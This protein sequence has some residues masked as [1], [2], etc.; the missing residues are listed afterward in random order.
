MTRLWGDVITA[1]VIMALSVYVIVQALDLPL[2]GGAM[3][4]FAAGF[5][6]VLAIAW[7]VRDV[8]GLNPGTGER[9][10]FDWSYDNLKPLV[11]VALT[12]AY[13][14]LMTVI[15]FFATTALFVVLGS[16]A[17][18]TRNLRLLTITTVA[19]VVLMYA[20]F[21][22]ALGTNLPRGLLI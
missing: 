22:I 18:G 1:A 2:G 10:S 13:A 6:L 14:L 21:V 20:F 9:L 17:L 3:P 15:G 4:L 16:L 11:I 5:I 12:V 7:I 8:L 19:L